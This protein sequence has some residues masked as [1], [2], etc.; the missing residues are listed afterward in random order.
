MQYREFGKTGEMVSILGFGCMRFPLKE[1]GSIAIDENS[2]IKLLRYGIDCGINYIDTAYTYHKQ[3]SEMVVGKALLDGYREK[4][5]I[6]TKVPVWYMNNESDFDFI[7]S[8]QL[9]R[10]NVSY[11]DFYLIHGLNR[12]K[13]E[14][15][16]SLHVL[17]KMLDYKEKGI[18]KHIGFSFHGDFNLFKEIIDA[19]DDWGF[20]QLML[21][22]VLENTD[23]G[24]D[25]M[26]IAYSKRMGLAIMEPLLGGRLANLSPHLQEIFPDSLVPVEAAFNWLWK[27]KEI[28]VVLSGMNDLEQLKDN[29]R[30]AEQFTNDSLNDD[31]LD[32]LNKVA[33]EFRRTSLVNCT[34][35]SYCM[36]CRQDI[37]IPLIFS[38]YNKS[39]FDVTAKKTYRSLTIQGNECIGCKCCE[40]LCPQSLHISTLMKLIHT[41]FYKT[42]W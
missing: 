17:E 32:L 38:I 27:K 26:K 14:K 8:T 23:H 37:N 20:C 41:D 11:I 28:S 5:K 15:A 34:G 16:K 22:Y 9:R 7:I 18:I 4:V 33:L 30:Y 12:E 3:K 29:I 21:N 2:A 13:W 39:A 6:A 24:L 19:S 42:K 1:K 36:P 10:L 31:N 25:E 40:K 35:C